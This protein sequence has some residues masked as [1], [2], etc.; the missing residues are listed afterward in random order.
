MKSAE[1]NSKQDGRII[2]ADPYPHDA[3]YLT[4]HL[5]YAEP[6]EEELKHKSARFFTDKLTARLL[7]KRLGLIFTISDADDARHEIAR[8]AATNCDP[9]ELNEDQV[10]QTVFELLNLP[11]QELA[12]VDKAA[13][14][15]VTG[16]K[17][18]GGA[19]TTQRV[20]DG[21]GEWVINVEWKSKGKAN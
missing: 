6:S 2:N 4:I 14:D 1:Y 7:A 9:D 15:L 11:E 3:E 21:N 17:R 16:V 19:G 18:M 13:L 5:M 10:E 20:P 8:R 12:A